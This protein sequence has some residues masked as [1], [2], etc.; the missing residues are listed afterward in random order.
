MKQLKMQN[1]K[2]VHTHQQLYAQK[3]LAD[4]AHKGVHRKGEKKE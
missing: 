4:A 3:P 1:T 2:V